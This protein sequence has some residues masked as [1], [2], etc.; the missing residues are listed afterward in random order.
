MKRCSGFFLF[1]A[2]ENRGDIKNRVRIKA[3]IVYC[4]VNCKKNYDLVIFFLTPAKPIRPI[5]IKSRVAGS[6][7]GVEPPV[8]LVV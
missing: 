8:E 5:P 7:T 1:P 2:A 4:I 6:G 3:I